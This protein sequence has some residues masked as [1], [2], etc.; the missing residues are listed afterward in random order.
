M[1]VVR[2]EETPFARVGMRIAIK[3]KLL[4]KLATYAIYLKHVFKNPSY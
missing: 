2:L 3:K 4:G 1:H